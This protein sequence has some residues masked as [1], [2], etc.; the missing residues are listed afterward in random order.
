LL[1]LVS[2]WAY[3][4]DWPREL[5][6]TIGSAL[7]DGRGGELGRLNMKEQRIFPFCDLAFEEEFKWI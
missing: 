1:G 4:F 3:S 7:R 5:G 2:T 6:H